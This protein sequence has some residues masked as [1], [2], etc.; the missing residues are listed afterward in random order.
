MIEIRDL[1]VAYE[2][3]VALTQLNMTVP[4]Q[5]TCA[6]IGSS[7]CG[8]TTLLYALAG[9]IKPK[10]GSITIQGVA[11]D[12]IRKSTGL[13]LQDYGL[14][15]WKTVRDNL[16]FPLRARGYDAAQTNERVGAMLEELGLENL[17]HRLPGELS[18]G[19][20]Q[21]VAIG[22]TLV[23]EPDVLLM[24]EASSALDAMT[25]EVI[26]NLVLRLHR[27]RRFTLVLVTHN[28][29][30][31][32]FLGQRIL[33]MADGRVTEEIDNPYFGETD[34]RDHST[35]FEMTLEIRR[36]LYGRA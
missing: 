32:V 6:V 20:K 35:F 8:K 15:P 33:V 28:I 14:L 5:S 23:L 19:Q 36:R 21:R 27:E 22:R 3:D 18:G 16:A 11:V 25:K 1:E 9:L 26:Q 2:R 31:A 12:G 13:V 7:G 10:A 29:E 30:E 17:G 4:A 24:D 34:F